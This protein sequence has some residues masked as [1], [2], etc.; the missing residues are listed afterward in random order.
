MLP[1]NMIDS[2]K[3]LYPKQWVSCQH[4]FLKY[5]GELHIFVLRRRKIVPYKHHH[6]IPG[7]AMRG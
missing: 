6:L 5:I 1:S 3:F 4:F 2:V 7:Q